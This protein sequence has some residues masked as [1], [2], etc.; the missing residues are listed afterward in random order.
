MAPLLLLF[1]GCVDYGVSR[2]GSADV[3]QQGAA[4]V[5]ADIL[6][7]V[8]NSASMREEQDTVSAHVDS[9]IDALRLSGVDFHI[10]VLTTDVSD[11][12]VAGVLVGDVL[13]PATADLATTLLDQVRVGTRGNRTEQ[14]LASVRAALANVDNA[15]L[16]RSDA[17]LD[18]IVLTDEDDHSPDAVTDYLADL[19]ASEGSGGYR[20]SSIAGGLP[21]GCASLAAQAEAGVRLYEAANGSDGLFES[22]CQED[23]AGVMASLGLLAAGMVD[24]FPLTAIPELSSLEVRVDDVLIHQRPHDGWQYDAADNAIVFDGYAIPRPGQGIEVR[25]FD[26]L[27]QATEDTGS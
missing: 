24:R 22:I 9:F 12:A 23:F 21:E 17:R 27:G 10:G 5:P 4:E 8:D 3:F 11:A 20:V 14:P 16:A 25:Y 2:V 6:W 15:P 19:E 1:V 26:F 13:T 7:V 18:V